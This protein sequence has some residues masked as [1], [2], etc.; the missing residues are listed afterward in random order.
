VV[1]QGKIVTGSSSV[2]HMVVI[3][4]LTASHLYTKKLCNR[5][6]IGKARALVLGSMSSDKF[7]VI[8]K[9]VIN[10]FTI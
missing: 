3:V 6:N 8:N 5:N 7:K 4:S 10:F 1:N 2:C 9:Y